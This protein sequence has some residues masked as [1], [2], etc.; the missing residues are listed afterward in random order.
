MIQNFPLGEMIRT[1]TGLPNLPGPV[2][3]ERLLILRAYILQPTRNKF[4]PISVNSGYRS[5]AVNKTI[6]GSPT[7]Q[8]MEGGAADIR[9]LKA[10]IREVYA[11]M[12]D[13]LIYGQ[14]IFEQKDGAEWIHVS[15]PRLGKKNMMVGIYDGME[16][17][18]TR[19]GV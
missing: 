11:W 5:P 17:L 7:S 12:R 15:I 6:S 18:W 2:E 16:Y 19:E 8:H 1:G 4:G 14:L 13:N 3:E 9:P 10:D